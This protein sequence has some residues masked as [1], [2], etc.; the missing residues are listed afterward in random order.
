MVQDIAWI[1]VQY[2]RKL[3]AVWGELGNTRPREGL[4]SL[5]APSPR[6]GWCSTPPAR[7]SKGQ[8]PLR[9]RVVPNSLR[10]TIRNLR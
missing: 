6:A 4:P 9:D 2:S 3:R 10:Q 7:R 1:R 5:I 8:H